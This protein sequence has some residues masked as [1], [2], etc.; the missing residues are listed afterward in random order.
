MTRH[1]VNVLYG[2]KGNIYVYDDHT[3]EIQEKNEPHRII[4]LRKLSEYIEKLGVHSTANGAITLGC[5]GN[6][7]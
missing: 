4:P 3:A 5:W 6:E 2:H 7:E 1:I